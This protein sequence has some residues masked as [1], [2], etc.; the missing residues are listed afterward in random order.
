MPRLQQTD[1]LPYSLLATPSSL[2]ATAPLLPATRLT[3]GTGGWLDS[4]M[5]HQ[6]S[7]NPWGT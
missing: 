2:L 4:R 3:K 1:A 6:H 5:R 7:F